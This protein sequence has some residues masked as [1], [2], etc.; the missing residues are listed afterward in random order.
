MAYLAPHGIEATT[1]DDLEEYDIWI[2]KE[3]EP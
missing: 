3:D 1:E 2:T